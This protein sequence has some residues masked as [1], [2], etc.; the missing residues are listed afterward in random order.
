MGHKS[1][2]A[3][4]SSSKCRL[5]YRPE[6]GR[7]ASKPAGLEAGGP[8][9]RRASKLLGP[10]SCSGKERRST[11]RRRRRRRRGGGGGGALHCCGH[12]TAAAVPLP[13]GVRRPRAMSR[14][15][16][17]AYIGM[18]YIV[19]AY[20]VMAYIVMAYVVM[21]YVVMAYIVMA[22]VVM[23]LHSYGLCSHGL[24]SYGPT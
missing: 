8:R 22:S 1:R 19:V 13:P 5:G 6:Q 9:S 2:R 24:C 18:A 12:L 16:G 10:R 4:R 20:I 23:A 14:H 11:R 3:L 21:A 17:A 15:V 7:P